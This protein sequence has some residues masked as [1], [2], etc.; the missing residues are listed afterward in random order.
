MNARNNSRSRFISGLLFLAISFTLQPFQTGSAAGGSDN[1]EQRAF[2]EPVERPLKRV[3]MEALAEDG[4]LAASGYDIDGLLR[5]F[6]GEMI[7]FDRF[8]AYTSDAVRLF[9]WPD[10][11]SSILGELESLQLVLVF[12]SDSRGEWLAVRAI[13]SGQQR[14]GWIPAY[15]LRGSR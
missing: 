11:R 8:A 1:P 15:R 3:F 6:A 9:R 13:L 7:L 5:W 10:P 12:G 14:Y 4:G 2:V